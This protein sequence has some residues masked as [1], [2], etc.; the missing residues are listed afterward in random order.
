[1]KPRT[2][3]LL[4][5]LTSCFWAFLPPGAWAQVNDTPPPLGVATPS[6]TPEAST[7]KPTPA[8]R[9]PKGKTPKEP[10][11]TRIRQPKEI[12]FP[13]PIGKFGHDVKIPQ[14]DITGQILQMLQSAKITR[15]DN[16]R[17]EMHE[18]NIDLFHPDGKEDFHVVLPD[19]ILNLKTQIISSDHP[20]TVRTDDFELTGE[21]MQFNTVD[22]TGELQ[23]HVHMVI[24]NLKQVAG[25]TPTTPAP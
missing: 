25:M 6:P 5:L 17:V 13:L 19:S 3:E 8:Q 21:R 12:P 10:K 20:V 11:A 2:L 23:G 22:R 14:A 18:T 24:R 1:M 7:Q 9:D 15:L 16:E 4:A